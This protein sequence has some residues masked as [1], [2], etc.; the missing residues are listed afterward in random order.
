MCILFIV[1]IYDE[2]EYAKYLRSVCVCVC[3]YLY[4]YLYIFI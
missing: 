3:V 2:M 4:L 1:Y